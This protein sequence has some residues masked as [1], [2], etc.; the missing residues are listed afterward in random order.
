MDIVIEDLEVCRAQ[1]LLFC[2]V[3]ILRGGTYLCRTPHNQ[4]RMHV[5]RN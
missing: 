4:E 2:V 3:N 5:Q 1:R